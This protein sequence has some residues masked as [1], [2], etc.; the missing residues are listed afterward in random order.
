[1][2]H[3]FAA[4]HAMAAF[5]QD[6]YSSTRST[7]SPIGRR[8][9]IAARVSGSGPQRR[10]SPPWADAFVPQ[11]R[12]RQGRTHPAGAPNFGSKL[13]SAL[14]RPGTLR[15]VIDVHKWWDQIT[16]IGRKTTPVRQSTT[17]IHAPGAPRP[18][19]TWNAGTRPR[20]CEDA[21]SLCAVA[22]P[23]GKKSGGERAGDRIRAACHKSRE[24]R[25]RNAI[26]CKKK[27]GD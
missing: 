11:P 8:G 7:R 21:I 20:P 24:R 1:M 12:G 14:V 19:T 17:L 18:S 25:S 9:R 22:V 15:R 5:N 4:S 13:D 6:R 27:W 23:T 16:R 3:S 10:S 2:P 26:Q